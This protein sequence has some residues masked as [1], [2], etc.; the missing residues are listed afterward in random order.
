MDDQ[1]DELMD[2]QIDRWMGGWMDGWTSGWM[3]GLVD[4]SQ[5][6][7]VAWV[8][9]NKMP[10]THW[11]KKQPRCPFSWLLES[12]VQDQSPW[13]EVKGWFPLQQAPG[14]SLALPAFRGT[15]PSFLVFRPFSASPLTIL[16]YYRRLEP[17]TSLQALLLFN[18]TPV[19]VLHLYFTSS[20][21]IL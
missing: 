6:V 9:C 19:G 20:Q 16:F 18:A 17:S 7:L 21:F 14:Q 2:G 3:D 11:F 8:C 1:M 15:L 13:A 12:E 10:Q 4:F 5:C